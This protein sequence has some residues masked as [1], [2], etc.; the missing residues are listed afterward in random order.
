[1]IGSLLKGW[2]PNFSNHARF[3]LPSKEAPVPLLLLSSRP[4]SLP[5]YSRFSEHTHDTSPG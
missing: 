2:G 4:A 3:T 5:R 1:M